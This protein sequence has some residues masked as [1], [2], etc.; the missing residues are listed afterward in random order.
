MKRGPEDALAIDPGS[1]ERTV[2]GRTTRP[3]ISRA[4]A[5]AGAATLVCMAI[6][7]AGGPADGSPRD[8]ARGKRVRATLPV[9]PEAGRADVAVPDGIDGI[10]IFVADAR[11]GAA[12]DV[13]VLAAGSDRTLRA[14][15]PGVFGLELDEPLRADRIQ[16]ALEPVLD[17]KS[18]A[19]VERVELLR[20]G[21]VVGTAEIR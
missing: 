20:G 17:A 3:H 1:H 2:M 10:R 15:A 7:A 16:V 4:R 21:A 18:S 12:T 5:F 9:C 11:P 19:C 6:A 14:F 8:G 13:T